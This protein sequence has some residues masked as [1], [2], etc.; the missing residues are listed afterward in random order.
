MAQDAMTK[1]AADF[2]SLMQQISGLRADLTHLGSQTLSLTR[3]KAAA[4][5]LG[6]GL[7]EAAHYIGAK[8]QDAEHALERAVGANP[9]LALGLATGVGLLL[10]ALAR[11]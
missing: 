9:W 10:G 11:K 8:G 3:G 2:E 6:A 7:T 5:E 1:T 4:D